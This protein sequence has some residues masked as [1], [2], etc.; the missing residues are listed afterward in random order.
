MPIVAFNSRFECSSRKEKSSFTR[1][2]TK[3][4]FSPRPRSIVTTINIVRHSR[5]GRQVRAAEH[6]RDYVH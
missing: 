6:L 5:R 4:Y 1:W 3:L 2:E